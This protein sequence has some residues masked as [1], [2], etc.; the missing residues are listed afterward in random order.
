L[1]GDQSLKREGGREGEIIGFKRE[2]QK[3]GREGGRE[4]GRTYLIDERQRVG[5]V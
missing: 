4:E 2:K 3:K 1:P 5:R